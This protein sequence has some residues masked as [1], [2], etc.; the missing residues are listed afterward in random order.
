MPPIEN[1]MAVLVAGFFL[2]VTPGPSML[3]V[4][5]H[6]VG[7]S[8]AAGLASAVGLALGGMLLAVATALGLAKLFEEVPSVVII[9]RYLG[10]AYL[11]WLGLNMIRNAHREAQTSFTAQ[12]VAQKPISSIVWQG[13]VVELLN[14][15]TVLFFALFLPPFVYA[16]AG[17][18]G[19]SD[20]RLQLL[21]LGVLVP[22]TA[23][24]SDLMIAILGGAVTR[25]INQRRRF[26][27]R[28]AW[29]G[30]LILIMIAVNLHIGLI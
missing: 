5:S 22:L 1:V 10:S 15:K 29:T 13:V 28:L 16:G 19:V 17:P 11:V 12:K 14:P 20:V 23:I 4:L 3:Y 7:Q 2:S 18:E 24:P 26:R 30:G 8:R 9:L 25:T 6:S 27:E 21:V